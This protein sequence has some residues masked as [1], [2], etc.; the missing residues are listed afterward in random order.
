MIINSNSKVTV[1][2]AKKA[3]VGLNFLTCPGT[4]LSDELASEL[5]GKEHERVK[6]KVRITE[7]YP[8][9]R[10][11][12]MKFDLKILSIREKIPMVLIK[13]VLIHLGNKTPTP[14]SHL[15]CSLAHF[16]KGRIPWIKV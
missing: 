7:A 16:L 15:K 9:D 12:D 5:F 10:A 1:K 8:F 3:L 4:F 14:L 13:D 11:A 6:I 2:E